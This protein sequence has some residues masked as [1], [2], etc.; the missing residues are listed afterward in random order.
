MSEPRFKP[1]DVVRLKSQNTPNFAKNKPS[2]GLHVVSVLRRHERPIRYDIKE[3]NIDHFSEGEGYDE[4]WFE[5][6]P[7]YKDDLNLA[8]WDRKSLTN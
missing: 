5:L 2:C 7:D 6:D 8:P 4:D 3:L 1:G